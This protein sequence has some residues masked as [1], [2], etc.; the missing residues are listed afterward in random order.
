[1]SITKLLRTPLLFVALLTW[2]STSSFANIDKDANA[3]KGKALAGVCA[4]CHGIDGNSTVPSQPNLAGMGWQYTARQ[5][6]HFKTGQRDNAIMKGFAAN[7]SDAD[8]K[9]LGAY[10]ATQKARSVGT[11]DMAA[12]KT[13]EKLY[14]AGDTA[15]G[16]PACAG[17]HSPS[18]AGIPGQYPRIGGQHAEYT[19]AQLTAFK[20]GARGK[21][22]KEDAHPNGKMMMS[23]ASK[24]T[25]AE[26]KALAEY[27]AG[28]SAN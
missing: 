10:Y 18:G 19:L 25:D 2:V 17:C 23:I 1:M 28:L 20:S 15:R 24:L 4:G 9:A 12:A 8:M 16:I 27:T 26:M 6:K 3:E 13:V 14:R 11:K 7:L 5:L 22:T 21:A